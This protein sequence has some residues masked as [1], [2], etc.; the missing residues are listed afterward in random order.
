MVN[1]EFRKTTSAAY[2]LS[3]LSGRIGSCMG[4]ARVPNGAGPLLALTHRYSSL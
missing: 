3:A 4:Y 2:C 1:V